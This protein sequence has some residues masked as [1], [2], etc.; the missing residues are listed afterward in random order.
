[1]KAVLTPFCQY[2]RL[3]VLCKF[4]DDF[5]ALWER[6]DIISDEIGQIEESMKC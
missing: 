6:D 4:L 5:W 1:M 3:A 2:L